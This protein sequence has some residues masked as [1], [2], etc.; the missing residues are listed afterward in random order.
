MNK[1][2]TFLLFCFFLQS[3]SFSQNT[4]GLIKYNSAQSFP[5]YNLVYPHNQSTVYLLDN[6]GQIVHQWNDNSDLRPGNSVYL[7]PNGDLIK[8]K[9]PG[10]FQEDP[11]WA[12]GGGAT[13]ERLNWNNTLKWSFTKNDA[14]GRLHHDIAPLPN[15]N[16]LMIA[17]ELKSNEEAIQ[18]GRNP[19]KIAQDKLWPD[20]I[21]EYNPDSNAIVWEWNTW[22]HLVQDF[23]ATKD[24]FGEVENHPELIDL[25]WDNHN[26][27]PDWL[28]F[29]AI[30]Y[31][32]YLDQIVISVPYFDEIWIIDHSTTT[33]EAAGHIG[34][35]FG[36]GGDLLYRW[37]NPTTYKRDSSREQQLFFSHDVHWIN[38]QANPA[39]LDF[40]KL[41]VFNNRLPDFSSSANIFQ[42]P[43]DLEN[44]EYILNTE[45]IYGPE[46][47][48]KV[49]THPEAP[50]EAFSN[51]ISS[52][53]ILP[54]G[55]ALVCSGR[56][57]FSYEL[58]PEDEVVWE[59]ILPLQGGNPV[60]QGTDLAINDNFLFRLKRYAETYS[61]FDNRNL[62]PQ[63]YLEL[64][65][66][67]TICDLATST[68]DLS[69]KKTLLHPNPVVDY[70]HLDLPMES[71][72]DILIYNTV[73]KMVIKTKW[74]GQPIYLA[75]LPAGA[76]F[77]NINNQKPYFSKFIKL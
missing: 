8:T 44:N 76:Y 60:S 26:G 73:G 45:E 4:V 61:G 5:G 20:Q 67:P 33:A 66:D 7:M 35:N 17:W 34:G 23:D 65:P 3:I 48:T 54:N 24:N 41:A 29:N 77:I 37:G 27:H 38:P 70:L 32:E 19:E 64:N 68:L 49:L 30:D 1:I 11:I 43:I 56:W 25:N 6:C 15:G 42:T 40:G 28:H 72:A 18:A 63:E 53:Q 2:L 47:F 39:D 13:V 16:V 14:Q 46:D 52:V 12:G 21:I 74:D 75:S 22:D 55:N 57:G 58:S 59:Y 9:R 51:A 62:D 71:S 36:K 31:N 10:S 69:L 50:I